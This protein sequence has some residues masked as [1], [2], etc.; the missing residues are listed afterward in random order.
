M[1]QPEGFEA[2][3]PS[4]VCKLHKA[5]YG[6]KQ[7]PQAWFER[8]AHT[9]FKLGFHSSKCDPS[10]FVQ[11]SSSHCIYVLVYVDDIIITGSNSKSLQQLT[12]L[13]DANFS[14]KDLGP[15]HYFLGIAVTRLPNGLYIFHNKS[16]SETCW[17]K[18]KWR[19][20]K[21]YQLLWFL[22]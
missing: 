10:L 20:P 7:A 12:T 15:L 4:L 9:L 8:L 11:C 1:L 6:L 2:A 5:L 19:R 14:L 18:V 22:T 17:P 16:T 21:L 13:L 3:D